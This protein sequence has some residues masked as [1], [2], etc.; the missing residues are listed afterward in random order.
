MNNINLY[1]LNF[2]NYIDV[3]CGQAIKYELAKYTV[4]DIGERY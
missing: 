4:F 3:Y 2:H 1:F